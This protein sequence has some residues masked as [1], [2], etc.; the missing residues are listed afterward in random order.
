MTSFEGLVKYTDTLIKTKCLLYLL[1]S[2]VSCL[3]F[4]EDLGFVISPSTQFPSEVINLPL[5]SL[6]FD[7]GKEMVIDG[8]VMDVPDT[9][10]F[11]SVL[12]SW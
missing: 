4:K 3:F 7:E 1:H 12:S 9:V 11:E 10:S 8:T 5:T 2:K 6:L